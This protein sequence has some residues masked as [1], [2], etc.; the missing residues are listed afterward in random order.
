MKRILILVVLSFTSISVAL[1]QGVLYGKVVDSNSKEPLIGAVVS[2][3]DISVATDQYGFYS[4][5]LNTADVVVVEYAFLG[6][7]TK[8]YSLQLL[9]DKL[10]NVELE[11]GLVVLPEV[12]VKKTT[13]K[14]EI[15]RIH[16]P[17]S[18]INTTPALL[19]E[20]D[21][22]KVFQYLPSI[23]PANEGQSNSVI[24][25]QAP[26][27]TLLIIDGI[28]IYNSNHA[29]G[30]LSTVNAEAVKDMTFYNGYQPA[31]LGGRMGGVIKIQTK[32]GD[33]QNLRGNISVG[34]ISARANIE[35]PI[36][37]D[38]LS[39][40]LAGRRSLIDLFIPLA[41]KDQEDKTNFL[42][43]DS[44]M[45]VSYKPNSRL[46]IALS[47]LLSGDKLWSQSM[48]KYANK[49]NN[50]NWR[51]GTYGGSLNANYIISP[52]WSSQLTVSASE[53]WRQEQIS[54]QGKNDKMPLEQK[55]K[56]KVSEFNA[57]WSNKFYL[58]NQLTLHTGIGAIYRLASIA[59]A[60]QVSF[61]EGS[62][63]FDLYWNITAWLRAQGGLRLEY[64]YSVLSPR[65][66]ISADINPK[67]NAEVTYSRTSQ[68]M[69]TATTNNSILQSDIWFATSSQFPPSISDQIGV[70]VYSNPLRWLRCSLGGYYINM[71]R[72]VEYKEGFVRLDNYKQI[73][74]RLSAGKGYSYGLEIL[75]EAKW[76]GIATNISYSYTK[77]RHLFSEINGGEWYRPYYDRPHRLIL[78][79]SYQ[80]N[81]KWLLS[82]AWNYS[83]GSIQTVPLEVL[84][85]ALSYPNEL[86][87]RIEQVSEKNNYRLPSYHR[88]DIAV[89]YK[90]RGWS[91]ALSVYNAYNRQNVYR[92]V[93][94]TDE[95]DSKR[96]KGMTLLPIIPGLNIKYSF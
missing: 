47:G 45:K 49:S 14:R 55:H 51:W 15:G 2:C 39:L 68:R 42:F 56:N 83:S 36:I 76:Q 96:I 64:P 13:S 62:V 38:K 90:H 71:N 85:I 63:S 19:A 58:Y 11:E 59:Q 87:H 24:R 60:D 92:A 70:T 61:W 29:M 27:A 80:I 69:L 84:P 86:T 53:F 67:T 32:D 89:N 8:T 26:E 5:H 21:P 73:H 43:Y 20:A 93:I 74:D 7:E 33:L 23:Q 44:N 12:V 54:V 18:T 41:T 50:Q 82:A 94:D 81:D 37:K 34:V 10:M 9:E 57:N 95:N 35:V 31:S 30:L 77:V 16:I 66:A 25:G 40:S 1:A 3:G 17:S 6:Y 52:K 22:I 4:L 91:F 78:S 48:D 72:L 79:T 88:L 65:V 46:S 75:L 28:N